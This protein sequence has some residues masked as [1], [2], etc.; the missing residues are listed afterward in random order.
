MDGFSWCQRSQAWFPVY[1]DCLSKYADMHQHVWYLCHISGVRTEWLLLLLRLPIVQQ[2]QFQKVVISETSIEATRH[3]SFVIKYFHYVM[4][5]VK[6]RAIYQEWTYVFY[7]CVTGG[8]ILVVP[9]DHIKTHN[10]VVH[11]GMFHHFRMILWGLFF[12]YAAAWFAMLFIALSLSVWLVEAVSKWFT[13]EFMI[14]VHITNYYI[15]ND[16]FEV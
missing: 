6:L 2:P 13:F 16:W 11:M 7:C 10:A 5:T 9:V 3:M 8:M 14:T 12:A 4:L 15:T 1:R